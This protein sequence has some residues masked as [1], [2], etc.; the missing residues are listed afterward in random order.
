MAAGPNS[1][2]PRPGSGQ[3]LPFRGRSIFRSEAIEH[4]R[5]SQD[6]IVFPRF[7]TPRALA[8]LWVL[9]I[10]FIVI[11]SAVASRALLLAG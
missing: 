6:R 7:T 10:F 5:K 4:Y 9:A 3:V 8:Y 1:N 11:G 2:E